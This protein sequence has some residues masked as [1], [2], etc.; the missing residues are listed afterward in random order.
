MELNSG[1]TSLVSFQ[2]TDVELI[3]RGWTQ[4]VFLVASSVA[5]TYR[6]LRGLAWLL[7]SGYLRLPVKIQGQDKFEFQR[8]NR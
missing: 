1:A 3:L 6:Q 5:S 8:N 2:Q 7:T 4:P